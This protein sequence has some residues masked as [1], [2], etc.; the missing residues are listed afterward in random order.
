MHQGTL[1][2][3]FRNRP[4]FT[5]ADAQVAGLSRRELSHLKDR[6]EIKQI[7]RGFYQADGASESDMSLVVAAALRPDATLCLQSALARH[8]LSDDIPR[9]SDLALPRGRRHPRIEGPIV[10]HTFEA[11][12]FEIGRE[13]IEVGEGISLGMYS[14]ERC[15]VDA[16]RLRGREGYE[17]ANDALK[18]WL[19]RPDSQP[20]TLLQ[21]A[22]HFSR[23][24]NPLRQ[25]LEILS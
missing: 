5:Y 25:A 8:G 13:V 21:M 4:W 18:S 14:P 17:S 2:S 12:T 11:E 22:Q 3:E 9:T 7:A 16:F 1:P 19:R 24:S 15:I 6:G 23:V 10:W 20:S